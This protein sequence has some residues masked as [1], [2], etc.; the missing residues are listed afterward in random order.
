MCKKFNPMLLDTDH[1]KGFDALKQKFLRERY[2]RQIVREG[3]KIVLPKSNTVLTVTR[4][5]DHNVWIGTRRFSWS[6]LERL[7]RN[8]VMQFAK[9]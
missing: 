8:R 2:L 9:A 6:E 1:Q 5:S 3:T 4:V 7:I